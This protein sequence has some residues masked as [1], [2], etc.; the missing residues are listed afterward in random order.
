MP[1]WQQALKEAFTELDELL[2]YLE[3]D[4]NHLESSRQSIQQFGLRVPQGFAS[5]MQK[6]DPQDPLLLQ[7]LP[8]AIELQSQAGFERNPVGDLEAEATPGLL[9]KYSGRALVIATGA[10]AVHCRYCFRR[11]YP[12]DVGVASPRQWSTVLDYLQ[13][14]RSISEVILS[15]GDPLM[16]SDVKLADWF[17]HLSAIPHLKRLRIHTRLPVVL[18]ERVTPQLL[19]LLASAR[20]PT[21]V[22][23]HIN[24]PRELSPAV[25]EALTQLRETKT[26]LLNQ[27]VLLK[28]IN[29]SVEVLTTLSE[30]LFEAGVL[31]YYL[32]ML[33]RVEGAAHFEVNEETARMIYR[34]LLARLP[35][36]LVPKLVREIAGEGSKTPL[37]T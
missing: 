10:C 17:T 28:G 4:K 7:V 32:H 25:A 13:A 3:L 27:S 19:G 33:D 35:G 21:V 23:V 29:D 26:T 34:G 1:G 22:V 6:G 8:A 16:L 15:G 11:H 36:Y 30:G 24:H 18:P 20:L 14:D 5:L 37:M 31:P 9:H 12:Y 2:D